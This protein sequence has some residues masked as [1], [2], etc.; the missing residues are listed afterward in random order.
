VIEVGPVPEG[1]N[2]ATV[3]HQSALALE[4]TLAL[5]ADARR[6]KLPQPSSLVVH[7]HRRS[8]DLPRHDDGSPA[9]LIH[10][11]LQHR[12]WQPL[13]AGDPLFQAGD[14]STIAYLPPDDLEGQPEWPVFI[15]E[16]AY[17]EKGIA[18]S[19]TSRERWPVQRDWGEALQALASGLLE[20]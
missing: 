11:R 1:V 19:L 7:R 2:T 9:A 12:D 4:A 3:V 20:A 18:L 8:L 13:Q 5:L 15:N 16:A 6:G 17:G 10:P 14:G